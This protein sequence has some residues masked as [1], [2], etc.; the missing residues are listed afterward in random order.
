MSDLTDDTDAPSRDDALADAIAAIPA[1]AEPAPEAPAEP[2]E[3]QPAPEASTQAPTP[4]P[5]ADEPGKVPLAALI[6]E[7]QRRRDLEQRLA[8]LEQQRQQPVPQ[9][10]AAPAA[11]TTPALPT[12]PAPDPEKDL[13]GYLMWATKQALKKA[14]DAENYAQGKVKEFEAEAQRE[15]EYRQQAQFI[16][17]VDNT[18]RSTMVAKIRENPAVAE[19]HEFLANQ[20]IAEAMAYG[21]TEEQAQARLIAMQREATVHAYRNEL[22][23]SELIVGRARA[24]GWQPAARTAAVQ[25]Q[26]AVAAPAPAPAPAADQP[27]RAEKRAAATSKLSAASGNAPAPMSLR[28][29]NQM[30]P[31]EYSKWRRKHGESGFEKLIGAA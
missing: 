17:Q 19:A 7:R 27:E 22:D 14:E 4:A 2:V 12:E 8:A 21:D 20:F 13:A 31:A 29:I 24:R 28:E 5:A 6:A 10:P 18:Y 26:P 30:T 23:L 16:Q 25:P 3:T 1:N 9:A 15:Q 11:A